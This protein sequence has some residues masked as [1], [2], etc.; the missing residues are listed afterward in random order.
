MARGNGEGSIY[1]RSRDGMWCTS[2]E[3]PRGLDGK[4]R[5][6]VICR[7]DKGAVVKLLREAQRNLQKHG[8]LQTSTLT[9]EAWL[10]KW[11]EEIAPN[12]IRPKTLASYRG[13]LTNYVAPL[14]GK[15]PL[16]KL[17]PE[18]IRRLHKTMQET[19][20][21]RNLRDAP[22]DEHPD[23]TEYLSSTY[24]LLTHNALSV[25]LK[26]ALREGRIH[27]NPCDLVDRPR[28]RRTEEK[29]L[30]VDQAVQ[31]LA[32]SA[33]APMGRLWAAY[34]LTGA[35]RG[36]LLGLE[37]D[38]VGDVLDLSWQLQRITD[39]SKAP[40]DWEYRHLK[41]T[42]YLTR[43]KSSAG[44][45][46]IPLVEPLRSILSLE[47][48]GKDGLVFTDGGEPWDPDRITRM[49]KAALKDAGLPTDVVLHGARHTTVDLLY[50]AKVPED[51]IMDIVGHST[52]SVTRGYRSRAD[53]ARL[54][55]AME[56]MSAQLER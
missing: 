19:P 15:K 25:A 32:Y 43:P 26:D 48:R 42:L 1:K 6:K 17:T 23:G 56:R 41:S 40:T 9:L 12:D 8:D 18:D 31:M 33:A 37:T 30:T 47:T 10:T 53:L 38:R 44:W 22:M 54:T 28:K 46:V 27:N 4:R 34:L 49:W 16:D 39:I 24:T 51:L 11:L 29:A 2:V 55:D 36:E 13:P 14:L 5:R 7:K 35:R 3:L 45:R 20:K 50:A 52:R 21:D